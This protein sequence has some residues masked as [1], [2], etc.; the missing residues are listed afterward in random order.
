MK[1]L[2]V[3][4]TTI[5]GA[6]LLIWLQEGCKSTKKI[7]TAI[8]K[9]DTVMVVKVDTQRE[10][11]MRM[12]NTT[13]DKF[14]ANRIAFNTFSAKVKVEYED[15]KE[16]VPDFTAFV[17]MARDSVIWIRIEALL[18]IEAFRVFITRDSVFVID[19]FK[20]RAMLRSLDY[21]QEIAQIPF[22][23]NTL[24]EL[25]VGNPVYF[26][27]NI[28]S[29]QKSETNTALLHIGE[30]FKHLVTFENDTHLLLHSKLDDVDEVRN[31]TCDLSYRD[32]EEKDGRR[33]STDRI[34]T[35]AEKSRLEIKMHFK[36]FQFNETL[37]FPFSIPS[38]YKKQ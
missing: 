5:I 35:V 30:L 11:S 37:N 18:G 29:Y 34:I 28:V 16:S 23:F 13:L 21:L 32:Y 17:R 38:S 10:D 22:D 9:K 15:S 25:I 24:Q 8:T 33:F 2:L 6:A 27:K 20:K 36:Q 7:Q 19:K 31:R 26:G 3:S 12:L 1:R 4:I 14:N